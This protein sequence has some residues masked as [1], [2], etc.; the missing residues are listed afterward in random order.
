MILFYWVFSFI[1]SL[2]ITTNTFVLLTAK[3]VSK[4]T[5]IHDPVLFIATQN[6]GSSRSAL[7][8]SGAQ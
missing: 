5:I 6:S 4:I 7:A 2:W 8:E 1:F 3:T